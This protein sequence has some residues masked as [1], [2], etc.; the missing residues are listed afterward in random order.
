MR[1]A[2]ATCVLSVRSAL[3][4]TSAR[5]LHVQRPAA[6]SFPSTQVTR[7]VD[8]RMGGASGRESERA[9]IEKRPAYRPPYPIS[10]TALMRAAQ[11]QAGRVKLT[12]DRRAAPHLRRLRSCTSNT[13]W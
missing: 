9:K 5:R 6:S 8:G 12:A 13:A 4:S 2:S 11:T 1:S 10:P 7:P 3:L